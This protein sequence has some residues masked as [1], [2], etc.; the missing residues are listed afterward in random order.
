MS[1]P[2]INL[3]IK[4]ANEKIPNLDW[5]SIPSNAHVVFPN[6]IEDDDKLWLIIEKWD[7]SIKEIFWPLKDVVSNY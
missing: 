2:S 7:G 6:K 3:S 1:L 4:K 5:I